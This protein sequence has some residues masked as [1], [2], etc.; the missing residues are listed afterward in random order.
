MFYVILKSLKNEGEQIVLASSTSKDGAE[1][2]RIQWR[3]VLG[4]R[5]WVQDRR[6]G[7]DTLDDSLGL[8]VERGK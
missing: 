7:L 3:R 2:Q 8:K 6:P 5:N 4:G 1:M